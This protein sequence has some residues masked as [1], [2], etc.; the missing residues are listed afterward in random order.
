MKV[1][2][3]DCPKLHEPPR[4]SFP[5]TLLS[6]QWSKVHSIQRMVEE[7]QNEWGT[8]SVITRIRGVHNDIL[9][10][11][12]RHCIP[13]WGSQAHPNC[14]QALKASKHPNTVQIYENSF[15][16]LEARFR[17]MRRRSFMLVYSTT[18]QRNWRLDFDIAKLP[19][20]RFTLLA[21]W[22]GAAG[23]GRSIVTR[24]SRQNI[25]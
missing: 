7:C 9:I 15:R 16:I 22:T 24:V 2:S 11:T 6:T 21:F 13:L 19:R 12:Y 17:P 18:R 4:I 1:Q 3:C 14:K 25:H 10:F 23:Y 8:A 20:R 5:A